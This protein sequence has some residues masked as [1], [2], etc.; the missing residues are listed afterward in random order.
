MNPHYFRVP[1]RTAAR[2]SSS[3]INLGAVWLIALWNLGAVPTTGLAAGV[4]GDAICWGDWSI[5]Y[6]P[7]GTRFVE[8]ATQNE[9]NA[10]ITA[11]GG[12]V[13]WG[14]V[15]NALA[16]VPANVT[17]VVQVA[18]SY[19]YAVALR[20]D[21]SVVAWGQIVMAGSMSHRVSPMS[22]R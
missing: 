12:V 4:S 22:L 2:T 3:R 9:G 21:R 19:D 5:P 11:D 20:A 10:G 7:A 6:V 17:S 16:E 1:W 14:R 18:L 8:I 13:V 15:P